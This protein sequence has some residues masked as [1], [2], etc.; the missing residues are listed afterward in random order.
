MS[1][2]VVSF[3]FYSLTTNAG[4][5]V[6]RTAFFPVVSYGWHNWSL[7]LRKEDALMA[8]G[9]GGESLELRER[10]KHE[11]ERGSGR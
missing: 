8:F 10:K 1:Q 9:W 2:I 5:E 11:G 6:Y 4:L 7:T 3:R